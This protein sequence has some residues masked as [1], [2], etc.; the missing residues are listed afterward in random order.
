MD[1][2]GTGKTASQKLLVPQTVTINPEDAEL[3]LSLGLVYCSLDKDE[4]AALALQQAV[5]IWPECVEAWKMLAVTYPLLGKK[6]DAKVASE[7]VKELEAHA[8]EIYE[9]SVKRDPGNELAWGHLLMAYEKEKDSSRL[10][11]FMEE[12]IRLYPD[13]ENVWSRLEVLTGYHGVKE[14]KIRMPDDRD[15]VVVSDH[16]PTKTEMAE[17]SKKSPIKGTAGLPKY[18]LE[19][20]KWARV[21]ERFIIE[22]PEN[23]HAWV[24]FQLQHMYSF[25]WDWVCDFCREILIRHPQVAGAWSQLRM[26]A[27]LDRSHMSE[28][29][30]LC[31]EIIQRNP[32]SGDAW[33]TLGQ[34]CN[35][36]DK[37]EEAIPALVRAVK[38]NP[39]DVSAW[40]CQAFCFANLGQ[41]NMTFE[42]LAQLEKLDPKAAGE[43]KKS[44]EEILRDKKQSG[45]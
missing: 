22:H 34:A 37:Y 13:D 27:A 33:R 11:E 6:A 20:S 15:I 39:K 14:Y 45:K 41:S 31:R 2:P 40:S 28:F 17:V 26:A 36:Q 43:A 7:Q 38:L 32:N 4:D 25:K 18:K 16:L 42:A 24:C 23:E 21:V 44:C 30:E 29:T 3:W 1:N 9:R 8:I 10:V 35:M 19:P 5:K 12:I